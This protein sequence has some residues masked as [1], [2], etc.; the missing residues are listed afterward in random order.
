MRHVDQNTAVALVG[1]ALLGIGLALFSVA[2]ALAVVGALLLGYAVL[3]DQKPDV[4][5]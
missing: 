4:T 2:V 1:L 3:P 5:P